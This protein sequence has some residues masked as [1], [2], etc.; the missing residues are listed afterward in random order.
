[1]MVVPVEECGALMAQ[2]TAGGDAAEMR[3]K[4]IGLEESMTHMPQV[5]CPVRHTFAPGLYAREMTIPKGV[6]AV[7]AIHKTRHITTVSKGRILLMTD[8]GI[9]EICAPYTGV[10]E[11]GIK[12]AAHALEDTVMTC[13]HPTNETDLDKLAEEL[14]DC[15]TAQ[16]CGG[17]EN[18][19]FAANQLKLKG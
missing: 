1:M 14:T 3:A 15:T 19:Q 13:Y 7:G 2:F 5:D 10:S 6:T 17:V 9:V 16:L 4:I 8:D 11:A 12:R 18:K